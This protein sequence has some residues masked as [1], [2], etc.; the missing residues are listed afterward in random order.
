MWNVYQDIAAV[1]HAVHTKAFQRTLSGT[2]DSLQF[3]AGMAGRTEV[4]KGIVQTR[5]G[6][7]L[8][9]FAIRIGIFAKIRICIVIVAVATTKDI[10]YTTL[11]ILHIGRSIGDIRSL[12]ICGIM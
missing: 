11:N 5:L 7:A 8:L 4:D 9:G 12:C 1:L 2:E 10:A 6:E 3:V